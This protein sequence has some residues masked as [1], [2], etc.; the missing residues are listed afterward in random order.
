MSRLAEW[1]AEWLAVW[2]TVW[3]TVVDALFSPPTV[4]LSISTLIVLG[5]E[6][7][8]LPNSP[9]TPK[10]RPHILKSAGMSPEKLVS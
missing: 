5:N 7:H 2:S 4:Q 6:I 9:D 3:L 8:R 1:L 10:S